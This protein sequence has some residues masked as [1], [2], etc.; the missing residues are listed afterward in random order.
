ME[1][2]YNNNILN[3]D[4][5]RNLTLNELLDYFNQGILY[6]AN[7]YYKIKEDEIKEIKIISNKNLPIKEN[8]K[9]IIKLILKKRKSYCYL[10]FFNRYGFTDEFE[11]ENNQIIIDYIFL[12]FKIKGLKKIIEKGIKK[13]TIQSKCSEINFSNDWG[14]FLELFFSQGKVSIDYKINKWFGDIFLELIKKAKLENDFTDLDKFQRILLKTESLSI[15]YKKDLISNYRA[16]ELID[17]FNIYK[18]FYQSFVQFEINRPPKHL[19][20][21][22][23]REEIDF[24]VEKIYKEFDNT[25][26]NINFENYQLSN[27]FIEKGKEIGRDF[28]PFRK[29]FLSSLF[30][31]SLEKFD[32]ETLK[33]I[34]SLGLTFRSDYILKFHQPNSKN[35]IIELIEF[36][37]SI[38]FKCFVKPISYNLF[39]SL[40]DLFNMYGLNSLDVKINF[41]SIACYSIFLTT[42]TYSD[43]L[44]EFILNSEFTLNLKEFEKVIQLNPIQNHTYF[45]GI[46]DHHILYENNIKLLIKKFK[47]NELIHISHVINSLYLNLLS[48]TQLN[49]NK[50]M[51]EQES[52]N[53]L[54]ENINNLENLFILNGIDIKVTISHVIRWLKLK[55]PTFNAY[56]Q[57]FNSFLDNKNLTDEMCTRFSFNTIL[58]SETSELFSTLRKLFFR[59]KSKNFRDYLEFLLH[60]KYYDLV[61]EQIIQYENNSK[62]PLSFFGNITL[63]M[64]SSLP[65]E[66]FQKIPL[67]TICC[68]KI[69]LGELISKLIDISIKFDRDDIFKYLLS[70]F[71]NEK[72]F[73]D[74]FPILDNLK[75]DFLEYF[76]IHKNALFIKHMEAHLPYNFS[77]VKENEKCVHLLSNHLPKHYKMKKFFNKK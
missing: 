75:I 33:T 76:L 49:K 11:I 4:T 77:K 42:L 69:A 18:W 34:S 65:I 53:Y 27:Y 16:L 51:S 68:G 24:I 28:I 56:F 46:F 50:I 19:F 8:E 3:R 44:L 60:Y 21:I 15:S 31:R 17:S 71:E 55:S 57:K 26:F 54:K 74:Y 32:I 10:D 38:Q 67:E 23:S 29:N 22:K 35:Q 66:Q 6:I 40:V 12:N 13:F 30:T 1:S 73:F 63:I 20:I 48:S 70:S 25:H 59:Y 41:N 45:K 47:P 52:N 2:F 64:E 72:L 39:K 5:E 61:I 37:K 9:E 62:R 58:N 7:D 14:E 43:T 36:L